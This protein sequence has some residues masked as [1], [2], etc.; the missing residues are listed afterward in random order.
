MFD[1]SN[2]S[3]EIEYPFRDK[4]F[5]FVF[6]PQSLT[7]DGVIERIL[8]RIKNKERVSVVSNDNLVERQLDQTVPLY[9]PKI[10]LIGFN[11]PIND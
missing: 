6:A 11:H 1:S 5:E 3:I 7:A 8:V 4:T 2:Q 10:Y 9:D